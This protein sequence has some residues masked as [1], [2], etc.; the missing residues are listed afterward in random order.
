VGDRGGEKS[1]IEV[2]GFKLYKE[3]VENKGA[4]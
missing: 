3:E 1:V 4:V 2:L